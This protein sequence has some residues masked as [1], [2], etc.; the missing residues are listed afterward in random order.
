MLVIFDTE[1]TGIDFVEDDVVQ[2]ASV[3]LDSG[4]KELHTFNR[5]AHPGKSIPA[6][7]TAVHGIHNRDVLSA[8]SSRKVVADWWKAINTVSPEPPILAGHNIVSFDLPMLKKHLCLKHLPVIDTYQAALRLEINPETHKLGD[9]H[10][11][12]RFPPHAAHDALGDCRMVKDLLGMY[13]GHMKMSATRFA[14]WLA[15]PVVLDVMPFGKWKGRK[16]RDIPTGYLK[17]MLVKDLNADLKASM[18]HALNH[19]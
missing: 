13:L 17:F 18:R 7:A 1:T 5:L 15:K 6:E 9:L 14:D 3:T 11:S 2:L 12:Y 8:D 16:F 10:A 4:Y 19:R